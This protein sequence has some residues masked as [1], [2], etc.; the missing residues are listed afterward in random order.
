MQFFA[1]STVN[2]I[3]IK[4]L[5]RLGLETKRKLKYIRWHGDEIQ[6]SNFLCHDITFNQSCHKSF[7]MRTELEGSI[8]LFEKIVELFDGASKNLEILEPAL[9]PGGEHV[10]LST[11]KS[12]VRTSGLWFY[13]LPSIPPPTDHLQSLNTKQ[14]CPFLN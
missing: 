5:I 4:Y 12:G 6:L 3:L 1:Y 2:K 11:E 8:I 14:V 10:R 13:Y 9:C 7:F